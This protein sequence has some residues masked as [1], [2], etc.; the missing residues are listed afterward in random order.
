MQQMSGRFGHWAAAAI[1]AA[2]FAASTSPGQ[3]IDA[4][5]AGG[6]I[7]EAILADDNAVHAGRSTREWREH[8][9]EMS[10]SGPEAEQE[11][12]GLLS[13]AKDN[14]APDL[15][16]RQAVHTLGRIGA[17]AREAV[18][19]LDEMLDDL[20]ATST[21]EPQRLWALK[22]IALMG[23]PARDLAPRVAEI[24]SDSEQPHLHR[25]V[26]LEALGQIGP[27]HPR[28]LPAVAGALVERSSPS[29]TQQEFQQTLAMRTAA[30]DILSLFGESA[31]PAIPSLMRAARDEHEPLR[32][33][34]V[35]TLGKT[36]SMLAL[37]SLV[38]VMLF[39]ES[40]AVQDAAATAMAELGAGA[41]PAL[42]QLL[43]DDDADI[44]W[45]CADA[46]R[47]IGPA[48]RETED[49]LAN[50]AR[51][52]SPL[53]RV[54]AAEALWAV[55]D[56]VDPAASIAMS[57]FAEPDRNLRIRAHRLVVEIAHASR[58]AALRVR[59]QELT[60]S[61][62]ARVQQAARQTLRELD[63]RAAAAK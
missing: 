39:D 12:P 37:D 28:T 52:P 31:A 7:E 6:G 53:V 3:E 11:V 48:A 18:P 22:A 36:R 62:D 49:S 23:R 40:P 14:S 47:R 44:R 25:L 21:G 2:L 10:L 4:R 54:V 17:P 42:E 50:L 9:K 5:E 33:A 26:A 19:L 32:R 45:R 61:E 57:L 59:L 20:E 51:D 24:L 16:R 41:A 15:L 29:D 27:T 63:L 30:A 1:A 13:L 60:S 55:A 56:E 43:E 38:D 35:T 46:L 8:F 58:D 34:A